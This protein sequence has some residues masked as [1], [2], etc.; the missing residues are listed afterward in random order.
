MLTNECTNVLFSGK[1]G[2]VKD[3][4]FL[5]TRVDPN[6]N[7]IFGT[8]TLRTINRYINESILRESRGGGGQ[9]GSEDFE[10]VSRILLG[11]FYEI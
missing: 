9:G 6:K 4:N 1:P 8:L 2:G 11:H 7:R 10:G 5:D 3:H